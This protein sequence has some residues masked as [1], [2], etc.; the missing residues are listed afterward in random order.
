[1]QRSNLAPE[2]D[3]FVGTGMN[4]KTALEKPTDTGTVP[5]I[6]ELNGHAYD[7][8][9]TMFG[10]NE[11]NWPNPGY[12]VERYVP[13]IEAIRERQPNA[14]LYMISILP[15][16]KG[17]KSSTGK[18]MDDVNELNAQL[19]ALCEQQGVTFIDVT[20]AL[21]DD[22]GFLPAEASSDGH[23]LH[24]AYAQVFI[25][26]VRRQVLALETAPTQA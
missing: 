4:V 12:I 17:Y 22:E 18:D 19:A 5:M 15:L 6:D 10:V 1:M 23:H 8:V 9:F 13:L 14:K 25:D 11:L 3:L 20:D 2:C 21:V 7:R 16:T 26:E 24:S